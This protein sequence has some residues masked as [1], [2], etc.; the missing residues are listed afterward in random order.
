MGNF[1]TNSS[2]AIIILAALIHA[3]FQA[4]VSVLTLLSGHALGKK[5]AHTR[6]LRLTG[7]FIGG[8]GVMSL[9]LLSGMAFVL[10]QL[11]PTSTPLTFW[12][13]SCGALGGVGISVWL[14]YYREKRGTSLWLPR[15]LADYLNA[16]SKATKQAAEAFG[17][18]LT[19]VLSELLFVFAPV[20]IT[21]LVLIRLDPEL[22][23]LGLLL[24]TGISLLP[25]LIVGALIG[26]GHTLAQIQRWRES[27]KQ[28]LQFAAGTALLVLGVYV[29]VD[30]VII[31]GINGLGVR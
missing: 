15:S 14:F 25:L 6:L 23:L 17:L 18:G 8:V 2:L 12:A 20:L 4:S 11:Y 27:N 31:T 1:D 28:F 22:Q 5:T 24:Y 21:A 26:G 19:S 13:A 9:L 7:G 3:S 16:R 10:S 30:R 29:Y